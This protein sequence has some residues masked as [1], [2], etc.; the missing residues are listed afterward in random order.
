MI[1]IRE[2][3]VKILIAQLTI[4]FCYYY[5]ILSK[6]KESAN[7]TLKSRRTITGTSKI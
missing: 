1:I 6:G 7:G 3:L 4:N 2:T 5:A